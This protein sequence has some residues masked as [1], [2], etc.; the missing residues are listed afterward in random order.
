MQF[1]LFTGLE[2]PFE[3]MAKTLRR[4]LSPLNTSED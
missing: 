2:P 3:L 1:Q 4:A